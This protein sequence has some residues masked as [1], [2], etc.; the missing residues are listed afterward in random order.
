[1]DLHAVG[2][3]PSEDRYL[4]SPGAAW[5]AFAM[6][7]ALM[8]FDYIDRQVIVSLFPHLKQEWHLSD[9]E[10]GGLVSIVSVT[11][12]L[13]GIPIA[14]IADRF[15][16][17]KSIFVM[18]AAWSLASISCMFTGSFGQLMAARA[19]VGL[20]EAGYGSVGPVLIAS[21]FWNANTCSGVR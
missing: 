21:H 11:V 7:V 12:A 13:A 8:V 10:L 17:V 2:H 4:I 5:F 3:G 16:R 14:L 20:G 15:S 19:M 6:T 9:R 18:A 1:M